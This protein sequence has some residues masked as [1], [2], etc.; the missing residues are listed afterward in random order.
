MDNSILGI[1]QGIANCGYALISDGP[2]PHK[3]TVSSLGYI[4]TFP[5]D[6]TQKRIY[7]IYQELLQIIK[8]HRISMIVTENLHVGGGSNKAI[9]NTNMIT[10]IIYLLGSMYDI[11]VIEVVPTSI[12]KKI[13]GSGKASK[14]EVYDKVMNMVILGDNDRKINNHTSDAIAL[15]VYG[16]IIKKE[17][18]KK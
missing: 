15:G 9:V 1:D 8:S 12:K 5:S 7:I 18:D 10:G 6:T 13:T 14:E 11:P 2:T 3:Y 16:K 4:K 17:E